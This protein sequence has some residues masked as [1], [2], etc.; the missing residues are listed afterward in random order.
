MDYRNDKPLLQRKNSQ[1]TLLFKAGRKNDK[2]SEEGALSNMSSPQAL[3]DRP[4][5][6]PM[7]ARDAR[8]YF[9]DFIENSPPQPILI[10]K[11]L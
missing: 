6:V 9:A 2:K 7:T 4:Q 1:H 8:P 10:P 3:K 5:A 11:N